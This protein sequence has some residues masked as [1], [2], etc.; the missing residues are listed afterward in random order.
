MKTNHTKRDF[1]FAA[2]QIL[3]KTLDKISRS[4]TRHLQ[5]NEEFVM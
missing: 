2:S 4:F 1:S 5:I 3:T